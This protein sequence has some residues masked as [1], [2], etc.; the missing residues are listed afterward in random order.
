MWRKTTRQH[1]E[2]G[3]PYQKEMMSPMVTQARLSTTFAAQVLT[4]IDDNAK[5]TDEHLNG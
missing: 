3:I 1:L 4:N 2:K 5:T